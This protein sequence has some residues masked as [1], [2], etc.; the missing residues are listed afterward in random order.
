MQQLKRYSCLHRNVA[1]TEEAFPWV[2]VAS[3]LSLEEQNRV[4]AEGGMRLD[5]RTLTYWEEE[6]ASPLASPSGVA[7]LEVE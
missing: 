5:E 7:C 2:E 1:N 6:A 4:E 3:C